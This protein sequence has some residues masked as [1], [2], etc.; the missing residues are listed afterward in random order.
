MAGATRPRTGWVV[1]AALLTFGVV[2]GEAL[3]LRQQAPTAVTLA[4]WT[5]T[6]ALLTA[7]WAFA[8]RRRIGTATYWR[9]VFWIVLFANLLMLVPVLLAGGAVARMTAALTSLI[10]PA[11]LAAYRYAYRS[12]ELW[13]TD[14]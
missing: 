11:Y 8:L 13:S 7:L 14:P 2:A 12:N 6:L 5:L 3:N 4:N 1:Y 10:V 9:A